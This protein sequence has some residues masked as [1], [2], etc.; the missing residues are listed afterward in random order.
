MGKAPGL[1]A[2]QGLGIKRKDSLPLF[3]IHFKNIRGKVLCALGS[4]ALEGKIL[5]FVPFIVLI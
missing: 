5:L 2:L 1:L 4:E 3:S